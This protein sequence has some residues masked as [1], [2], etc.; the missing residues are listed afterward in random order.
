MICRDCFSAFERDET[1]PA[2][3]GDRVLSHPELETLSIAHLDCDA[4][5]AA[6]EKRDR[7]ELANQ[8][9]IVGGGARG[10]VATCCYIARLYGVHSAMPI[11]KALKACPDAV[12]VRPDFD[13]YAAAAKVIRTLMG[14]LTPQVQPVSIDEAYMDLSGTRKLHGQSPAALLMRLQKRIDTE[15]GITVSIGLSVNKFLAKTASDLDKPRGFRLIGE[16][17][18]TELLAPRPIDFIHGVGPALARKVQA[19]GYRTLADLQN[20]NPKTLIGHFGETGLWL[21]QRAKGVDNRRVETEHDRKSV[22]AETTF[23]EDLSELSALEDRL[24][25]ACE[26]TA[27]RAKSAGVQGSVVTL[28]LKTS[29]FRSRTRRVSLPVP[30]QLG[31]TLFRC[32]R[33]LLAKECDGTRFRLIGVGISDLEPA[34]G[35]VADLIDPASLKRA[36]AERA[37]DIARSR[38]GD[39]AITTGRGVRLLAE[40]R[41]REEKHGERKTVIYPKD[42]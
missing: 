16:A 9:V 36:G 8:P 11:F 5:F 1:C 15:V 19:R 30:T 24:W 22:S 35:D 3:G 25:T 32:S 37:A 42:T 33:A 34:S 4:F 40:A 18:A 39:A 41:K 17:E 20:A 21:H 29:D 31:Q 10:V 12:I 6:V 38:F 28:K 26:K 2:C 13:K 23:S 14:E 27:R 7:P